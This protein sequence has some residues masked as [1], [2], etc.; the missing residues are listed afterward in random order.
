M[1][2][3]G[4][5][6]PIFRLIEPLQTRPFRAFHAAPS[7]PPLAVIPTVSPVPTEGGGAR[8]KDQRQRDGRWRLSNNRRLTN[9]C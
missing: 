3:I 8:Q 4:S 5:L 2:I 9:A 7:L 6:G 1:L